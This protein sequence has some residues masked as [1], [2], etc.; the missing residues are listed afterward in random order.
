MKNNIF[1]NQEPEEYWKEKLSKEA[2]HVFVKKE[3]N[4]HSPV[5]LIFI[6]KT[7]AINVVPAMFHYLK[8]A[9]SLKVVVVGP[10]LMTQLKEV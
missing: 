9:K 6:L 7:A 2:Y 1:P 8:V 4:V 3:Q 10:L 5:S